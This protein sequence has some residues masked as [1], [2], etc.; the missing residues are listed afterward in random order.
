MLRIKSLT[1]VS[2]SSVIVFILMF[3]Y[4][5]KSIDT[6]YKNLEIIRSQSIHHLIDHEFQGIYKDLEKLNID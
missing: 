5:K 4:L 1:V 6:D 2:I 3:I